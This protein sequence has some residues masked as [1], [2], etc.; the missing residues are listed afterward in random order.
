MSVTLTITSQSYLY[1]A[2]LVLAEPPTSEVYTEL[3]TAIHAVRYQLATGKDKPLPEVKANRI[4]PEL[5]ELTHTQP[6]GQ[7]FITGYVVRLLELMG[8]G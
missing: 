7:C 1:R 8:R 6:D 3:D 4:A 5:W 2:V